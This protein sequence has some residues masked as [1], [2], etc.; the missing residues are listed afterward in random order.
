MQEPDPARTGINW[1]PGSD[2]WAL[3]GTVR[4][5]SSILKLNSRWC[6]GIYQ[7]FKITIFFK[8]RFEKLKTS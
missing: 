8:K 2:H 3:S 7:L 6:L 1:P 5:Y 4:S